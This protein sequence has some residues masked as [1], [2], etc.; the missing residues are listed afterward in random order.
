MRG[1]RRT[2]STLI[3]VFL[4]IMSL[5]VTIWTARAYF[6]ESDNQ[7]PASSGSVQGTE[8]AASNGTHDGTTTAPPVTETVVAATPAPTQ[9][10]EDLPLTAKSAYVMVADSGEPLYELNSREA[11]PPGSTVKIVTALT[12]TTHARPEEVVTIQPEDVVDPVLESSMGLQAGDTVTVHDLLVGLM[13]PSGN[14]AARALAR[15][16]GDRLPGDAPP[17]ER[18][19][20]EMNQ[21]ASSLGMEQ[22]VF[23]N[24]SGDD[25]PGQVTTARDLAKAAHAVLEDPAL[26]PIV[27]MI[28]ANV[29]VG[30][31]QARTLALT[32][33]NELLPEN[34]VHGVKTGTTPDAGQCLVVAYRGNE[35]DEIAVILGSEDRYADARALLGLPQP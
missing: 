20:A 15:F 6:D 27:A 13:L 21:V 2:A 19:I 18:F 10:T 25:A 28:N 1:K 14:D 12:A 26:A 11:L 29:R 33:T 22:S 35:F 23:V 7:R 30:G 4:L 8:A 3:G 34:G 5:A 32:N 16:I 31:P 9:I 24:S 17:A